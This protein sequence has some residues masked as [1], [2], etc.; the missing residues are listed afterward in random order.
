MAS[1]K[2]TLPSTVKDERRSHRY[3]H[4]RKWN[5]HSKSCILL[6]EEVLPFFT[7]E[8]LSLWADFLDSGW[9]L[10]EHNASKLSFSQ[11]N[12]STKTSHLVHTIYCDLIPDDWDI[13][14]TYDDVDDSGIE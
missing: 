11:L 14:L 10:I 13:Q 3:L 7:I 8:L 12:Q 4:N 9:L 2:R 6:L 1:H 5:E